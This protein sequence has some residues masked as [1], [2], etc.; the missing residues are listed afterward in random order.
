MSDFKLTMFEPSTRGRPYDWS[1]DE[2][3]S[4]TAVTAVELGRILEH[5]SAYPDEDRSR[6]EAGATIRFASHTGRTL[7]ARRHPTEAQ[8]ADAARQTALF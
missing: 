3:R 2:G 5:W 1:A 4:W 8:R 6:I 7:W